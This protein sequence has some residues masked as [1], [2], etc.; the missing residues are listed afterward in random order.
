M[1]SES[2]NVAFAL[3]GHQD[4]WQKI[5]GFVNL[6]R[7]TSQEAEIEKQKIAE[8]YSYFPPC[9]I[10]DID[11]RSITGITAKGKY[12]ETFI[13]PDELTLKHWKNNISKVKQAADCASNLQAGIATLGGFTSIVLEGRVDMLNGNSKTCFTT[14]NTLTAAFI[15][16]AIE[17]ACKH[18]NKELKDQNILIIGSTGDIGSACVK[19]FSAKVNT[20]LLCARQQ[21]LLYQQQKELLEN[22]ISAK[23]SA[24]VTTLLPEA[25]I[26]IAIASSIIENFDPALC[27]KDVIICDAGYPKN[28]ID[29]LSEDLNERLF[30]GGM[31][32]VN[33]GYDFT[34]SFHHQLYNFPIP[35]IGHGCLLEAVVLSFENK[36][37]AYSTGKGNISPE[38]IEQMYDMAQKHGIREA[39]FF[40]T[41][42]VWD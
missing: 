38:K 39:P 34:P 4:S 2:S 15:V 11:V 27:K 40:N 21:N 1:D 35:N 20:L 8:V 36:N 5:S 25:D 19:Y 23:E 31:G 13:S 6:L 18:F 30:C 32:I 22:N 12:I 7:N 28:L 17:K 29:N 14:G 33:G 16:K 42:R 37:I 10:F 9:A 41:L 26:I 24:D 3:I